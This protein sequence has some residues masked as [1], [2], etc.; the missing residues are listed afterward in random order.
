MGI[1]AAARLVGVS[2]RAVLNVLRSAGLHCAALLNDK[3]RNL[4]PT[5][6]EI[7]EAWTF[8]Q[9][10]QYYAKEHPVFGDQY[11]WL[12]IDEPTKLILN[13]QISKR[14]RGA[15]WRFLSDLRSRVTNDV[16]DLTTDGYQ[17][18]RFRDGAVYRNFGYAVNYGA[19]IKSYGTL[20][21]Q[22]GERRYSPLICT[23]CKRIAYTGCRTTSEITVNHAERQNL[24]IRQFN[25]RFSRLT[26]GFSKKL[27]NLEHS[28]AL[29]V[30]YHNF[31]RPHGSLHLKATETASA[32]QQTPA[33][34]IGLTDHV[35][36]V[37]ELLSC[38]E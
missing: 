16:F 3:L 38:L 17:A 24:N 1:R 8:V 37:K 31:C 33:M 7:D 15:A 5:H 6:V 11:C 19:E 9:K 21:Q 36:T 29:M 26:L 23:S 10:K 30:A 14:T 2:N 13:W 22:K 12:S 4:K 18:Y 25:R 35:W 34:A 32:K 28:T 20:E 27:A